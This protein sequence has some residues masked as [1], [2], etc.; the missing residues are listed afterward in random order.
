MIQL[1]SPIAD[2]LSRASGNQTVVAS[3]HLFYLAHGNL[4]NYQTE[5]K[6]ELRQRYKNAP[7]YPPASTALPRYLAAFDSITLQH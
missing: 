6:G 7:N 5:Q 4:G 2:T 3:G 1:H